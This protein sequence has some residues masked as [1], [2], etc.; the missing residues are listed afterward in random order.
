MSQSTREMGHIAASHRTWRARIVAEV[1]SR[2][3]LL[4]KQFVVFT[5]DLHHQSLE[6]RDR[7]RPHFDSPNSNRY[8]TSQ[9]PTP[10]VKM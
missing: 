9:N 5:D 3:T 1:L 2:S 4:I 8:Q 6:A 7:F 10:K